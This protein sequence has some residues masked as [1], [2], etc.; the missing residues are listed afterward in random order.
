MSDLRTQRQKA[1]EAS[2]NELMELHKALEEA[3][4]QATKEADDKM[5]ETERKAHE[6]RRALEDEAKMLESQL[7]AA[8]DKCRRGGARKRLFDKEFEMLKLGLD[9]RRSDHE[10][11]MQALQKDIADLESHLEGRRARTRVEREDA[12]LRMELTLRSELEAT[13]RETLE[14]VKTEA[15]TGLSEE[16]RKAKEAYQ[17][18]VNEIGSLLHEEYREKLETLDSEH[19][20]KQRRVAVFVAQ[21]EA[22]TNAADAAR[23]RLEEDAS[24]LHLSRNSVDKERRERREKFERLRQN[25]REQW[26]TQQVSLQ[27]RVSF[28]MHSDDVAS[29]GTGAMRVYKDQIQELEVQGPIFMSIKKREEMIVRMNSVVQYCR[30]PEQAIRDGTAQLLQR[31]GFT[32]PTPMSVHEASLQMNAPTSVGSRREKIRREGACHKLLEQWRLCQQVLADTTSTL[33]QLLEQYAMGGGGK[34][35]SRDGRTA[36]QM[37]LTPELQ[38][39]GDQLNLSR[40][41]HVRVQY[42]AGQH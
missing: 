1:A 6:R 16:E 8:E 18:I 29:Y 30:N 17:E 15:A 25:I 4:Q 14:R 28:L 13:W 7:E 23:V 38:Q 20:D 3:K 10:L 11:T 33:Q 2:K 22:L 19:T 12:L 31:V 35:F 39:M 21:I 26:Q 27:D 34:A 41:T 36:Y 9:E 37:E 32:L 24:S 40:F 42:S 5:K